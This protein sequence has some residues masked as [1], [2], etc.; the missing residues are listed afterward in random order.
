MTTKQVPAYDPRDAAEPDGRG[1]APWLIRLPLLGVTAMILLVFLAI[2][3]VAAHQFQYD[4]LIY[5]GVSAFGVKLDGMTK[6]QALAA[7][8]TRYTY[9]DS[10]VFTFRDASKSWQMSARDLGVNFD[11]TKT[12]AD[13]Y[14]V[15]RSSNLL[16]N[17]INQ[18]D[19]WVNGH[20]IQPVV[21]FDESKATAFLEKIATDI[22]QPL[23]EATIVLAGTNVTTTPSQVG[24][25]LDI[26]ATLGLLR[27]VVL[28]M[29]TGAE[30]NLIIK[31]TQPS[32][33]DSEAAAEKVRNALGSPIQIY[34]DPA[35]AKS[36]ADPTNAGPWEVSPD[37]I[38][39]MLSITR[40]D[41]GNGS[42]H[43]EVAANVQPL[44]DFLT[45]LGPKLGV[46]PVNAR[47][48]FNEDTKQLDVI[49]D[50]VDG[51]ALDI[52]ATMRTIQDSIFQRGERRVP[53]IFHTEI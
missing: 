22:N 20:A 12:V 41:D 13:A 17:L 29:N 51:R 53:L 42:A 24:R 46:D 44:K 48:L 45:Q 43:Y 39:G 33:K 11:P 26:P 15:G 6:Q 47:F 10:A 34:M 21:V 4:S 2:L 38:S 7:L 28:N 8:S 36:L 30:I 32:V 9:G 40:I 16:T 3:G 23:H 27:P 5:P 37:F 52:D 50:S 14:S 18:G 31:E 25:E 49:Q 1:L 35:A 19:A